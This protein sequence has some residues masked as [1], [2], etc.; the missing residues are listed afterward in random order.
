MFGV[1]RLWPRQGV[2]GFACVAL[3]RCAECHLYGFV[4]DGNNGEVY[5]CVADNGLDDPSPR[6]L[7][8]SQM[9]DLTILRKKNQ[10]LALICRTESKNFSCLHGITGL[11]KYSCRMM[12]MA[13]KRRAMS[14]AVDSA[15]LQGTKC[16]QYGAQVPMKLI[17]SAPALDYVS[18]SKEMEVCCLE[19]RNDKS[20]DVEQIL[21]IVCLSFDGVNDTKK[22]LTRQK[23]VTE[24][25][26]AFTIQ[27]YVNKKKQAIIEL[28][29]V[30]E[31]MKASTRR[32]R[33]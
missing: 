23:S 24:T 1:Q 26:K 11:L 12:T 30:T 2:S 14:K 22:A 6:S 33:H 21:S 5:V 28:K 15:I 4:K 25:K 10:M 31:T 27:K 16:L 8:V 17:L 13:M 3:P 9:T 19:L 20:F 7:T 29:S 18:T 32:M